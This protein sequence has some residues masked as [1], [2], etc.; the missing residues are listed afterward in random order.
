MI[1]VKEKRADRFEFLHKVYEL[2]NGS[3]QIWYD[4]KEIGASLGFEYSYSKDIY[5]YLK[6]KSLI[7]PYGHGLTLFITEYGIDE[8][9]EALEQPNEPTEYFPPINQYNINIGNMNGGAI[10]QG[11]TNSTINITS[12][13]DLNS[14][15]SFVKEL[16]LFAKANVKDV[17]VSNEIIADIETIKHQAKSPKPK[18]SILKEILTS[19]RNTMEGATGGL[20]GTLAA[21]KVEQFISQLTKL[22]E[23]L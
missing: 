6:S 13:T 2:T 5:M 15:L 4:G 1:D 3:T 22:I 21:P 11:T 9:E 17:E 10:Q 14:I 7:K 16:E 12:T 20:I 19:I 8:I 18:S 23:N